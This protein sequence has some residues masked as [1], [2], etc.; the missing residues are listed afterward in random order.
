MTIQEL[1][2]K[3]NGYQIEMRRYFH[4]HPEAS[5]QEV[6]TAA[7]IREELDKIGV[8]WRECAKTG[9]L[10]VIEG[11]EPG[12]TILLRADIDA[13]AVNEATGAEYA[14]CVPG[15][16]HACGH[17]CHI[18]MLLTAAHM[19]NDLK[20]QMKGRVVLCF[21]PAEEVGSGANAMIADG[22]LEGVDAAFG[23]HVWWNVDAG[24]VGICHGPAFASGDHFEIEI[25]GRDGHGAEPQ[26][27]CDATVMA[28]AVVQ[29]LQTVV[30]RETTPIDTAVVT[31]GKMSSGTRWNVISGYA[32]L[33]GTTRTF[34]PEVQK[35]FPE[36]L[37][38]IARETCRAMRGDAKLT[39]EALVPVT[40]N[41]KAFCDIV[42]EAAKKAMGPEAPVE[43]PPTMGGEDF[44]NFIN[45]VPGAIV[46]LGIRNEACGAIYPQHHSK[47]QVDESALVG[48][49]A[50]Y[51]QVA[52]DY[53]GF[54]IK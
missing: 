30:S 4:Q 36:Q 52:C 20:D 45:R 34:Q 2:Q 29:N 17:D 9:T 3:Y 39:Y 49:A 25:F 13:L 31:V 43:V 50:L 15:L 28:A 10:A 48:G 16:M 27:A 44:S 18:S 33:E 32:K 42:A 7:R 53:L 24:K 19:L 14:S 54:E 5:N 38:R 40:V 51:T 35:R 37:E 26:A 22:A 1:K 23:M 21:Q 47:Y 41:D 46:F 12:K 11:K 8:K 6:N